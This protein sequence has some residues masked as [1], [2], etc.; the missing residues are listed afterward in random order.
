[1]SIVIAYKDKDRFIL[2]SD[3]QATC[4]WNKKVHTATKVWY[5]EY[6]GCCMGAVGSARGA[7]IMANV[8]GLLESLKF[9]TTEITESFINIELPRI[10]Y[11]TLKNNGIDVAVKGG[12]EGEQLILPC[13]YFF[14]YRDRCWYIGQDLTVEEVDNYMAMGSGEECAIGS[15]DTSVYYKEKNPFKVLTTAIDIAAERT[16]Y[17]DHEIEFV[18]TKEYKTDMMQQLEAVAPEQAAVIKEALKATK[19]KT[20][21]AAAKKSVKKSGPSKDKT[22]KAAE[23]D[24]P[25]PAETKKKVTKAR[26]LAKAVTDVPEDASEKSEENAKNE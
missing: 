10:I 6:E 25:T 13:A 22:V 20:K 5:N 18:S 24:E 16:L 12:D 21:K 3:K 4:G 1:M 23:I 19:E 2:G 8:Q 11:E 9:G 15:I 7:Q 26:A 17:V 14:A